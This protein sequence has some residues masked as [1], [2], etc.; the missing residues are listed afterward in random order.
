MNLF[1]KDCPILSH[2]NKIHTSTSDDI[3][4]AGTEIQ[5]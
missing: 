2:T 5:G 3:S 1:K 4:S